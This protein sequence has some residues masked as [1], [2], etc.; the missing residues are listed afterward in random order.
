MV[1][2]LVEAAAGLPGEAAALSTRVLATGTAALLAPVVAQAAV[3]DSA[4]EAVSATHDLKTV[5]GYFDVTV[6]VLLSSRHGSNCRNE[7]SEDEGELHFE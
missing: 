2:Y 5:A 4:A 7:K 3:L 6:G 1:K